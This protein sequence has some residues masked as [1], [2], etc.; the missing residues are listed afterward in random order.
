M[1]LAAKCHG[2]VKEFLCVVSIY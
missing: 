1:T 2:Y